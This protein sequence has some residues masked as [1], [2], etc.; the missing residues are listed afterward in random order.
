MTTSEAALSLNKTEIAVHYWMKVFGMEE[1]NIKTL[2]EINR[3]S[4]LGYSLPRIKHKLNWKTVK[5][6]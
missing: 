4:K 6:P 3:M 5:R 2:Q 1:P